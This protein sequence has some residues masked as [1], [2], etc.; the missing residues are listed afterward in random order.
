MFNIECG[1][2]FP[3]CCMLHIIDIS[4]LLGIQG[5]REHRTYGRP[6]QALVALHELYLPQHC[7]F[8]GRHAR[9]LRSRVAH[10]RTLHLHL[11]SY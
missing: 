3:A 11:R 2:F 4:V 6:S 9:P 10:L 7:H 8:A 5:N 1:A